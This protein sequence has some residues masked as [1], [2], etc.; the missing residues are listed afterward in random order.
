MAWALIFVVIYFLIQMITFKGTRVVYCYLDIVF[1]DGV[2][3][4]PFTMLPTVL[5]K[6]NKQRKRKTVSGSL[7]ASGGWPVIAEWAHWKRGHDYKHD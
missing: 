6:T 4:S 2:F 5:E 7:A 3:Y 1:Y